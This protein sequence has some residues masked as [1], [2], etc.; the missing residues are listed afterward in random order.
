MFH[1]KTSKHSK[2]NVSITRVSPSGHPEP[3]AF[4]TAAF[5]SLSGSITMSIQ[6]QAELKLSGDME[7]M[8]GARKFVHPQYGNL[9]WGYDSMMSAQELRDVQGQVLARV[10]NDGFSSP[11]LEILV[12]GG[13][14]F[15]EM[16]VATGV[17]CVKAEEKEVKDVLKVLGKV[18]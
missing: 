10:K 5:S 12:N 15:V 14:A 1:V 6:N 8:S 7:S 9:K 2:P 11:T 17:A 16:V 13:D 18:I 4:A 3:Q